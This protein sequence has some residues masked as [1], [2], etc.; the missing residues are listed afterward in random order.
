MGALDRIYWVYR[1]RAVANAMLKI[2]RRERPDAVQQLRTRVF[3]VFDFRDWSC[4][5]D[6][7]KQVVAAWCDELH[8]GCKAI[9]DEVFTLILTPDTDARRQA[10]AGSS[11]AHDNDTVYFYIPWKS[12]ER[13]NRLVAIA[14]AAFYCHRKVKLERDMI[15]TRTRLDP[16][17]VEWLF[18]FQVNNEPY[19]RIGAA[20]GLYRQDVKQVAHAIRSLAVGLGLNLRPRIPRRLRR[21]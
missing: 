9:K 20:D 5:N 8:L 10:P 15:P 1:G 13:K 17:H 11:A 4:L 14:L 21:R 7:T 12:D 18:R 19:D 16:K 6:A 2:V 3:E